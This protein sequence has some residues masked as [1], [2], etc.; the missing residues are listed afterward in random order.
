LRSWGDVYSSDNLKIEILDNVVEGNAGLAE[1]LAGIADQKSKND[2]PPV[3]ADHNHMHVPDKPGI[4]AAQAW[5]AK[6]F[7]AMVFS[8]TGAGALI[9]G[10]RI[11]LDAATARADSPGPPVPTRGHAIDHIGFEVKNLRAFTKKLEANGVKLDALYSKTRHKGFA[12]V[13]LTD[14]WGT[15]IE[16]TEGLAKY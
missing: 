9:P 1:H 6:H 2:V 7:G 16:L 5:Y 11:R 4:A 8:D 13:E 12:S 14:P 10:A 3:A 15:A